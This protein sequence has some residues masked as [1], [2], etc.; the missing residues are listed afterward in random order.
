MSSLHSVGRDLC[1]DSPRSARVKRLPTTEPLTE[2]DGGSDAEKTSPTFIV[3]TVCAVL[4]M[5]ILIISAVLLRRRLKRRSTLK[6]CDAAAPGADD[7]MS[8]MIGQE[9]VP[10]QPT[11]SQFTPSPV[12]QL[13][14]TITLQSQEPF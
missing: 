2:N 1:I 5:T 9:R 7:E 6:G 3:L 11:P 12:L 8:T 4:T 10:G 14:V 13:P